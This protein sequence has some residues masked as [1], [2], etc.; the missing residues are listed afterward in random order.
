MPAVSG[1]REGIEFKL[2]HYPLL[3]SLDQNLSHRY[4][5]VYEF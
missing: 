2:T 1:I 3:D 5:I 4:R